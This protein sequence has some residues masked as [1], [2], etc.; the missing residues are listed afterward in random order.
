[1]DFDYWP[2]CDHNDYPPSLT[3]Y[4]CPICDG[5]SPEPGEPCAAC[6]AEHIASD[7]P[8]DSGIVTLNDTRLFIRAPYTSRSV[9]SRMLCADCDI[10]EFQYADIYTVIQR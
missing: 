1:M 2:T 5:Y 10:F 8:H 7:Y 4:E 3:V 6:W 9:A